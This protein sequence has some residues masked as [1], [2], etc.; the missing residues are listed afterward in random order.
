MTEMESRD[1]RPERPEASDRRDPRT[2]RAES[3]P[4]VLVVDDD[5]PMHR[6][7]ARLLARDGV[8]VLAASD[9]AGAL[10]AAATAHPSLILLDLHLPDMDGLDTLRALR[11]AGETARVVILT[12]QAT[13]PTAREAMRLGAYDFITK[14]FNPDFVRA[15]LR[16]ALA[17]PLS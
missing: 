14:P 3:P 11:A 10:A 12:G 15:V 17:Q 1:E 16:K 2:P 9:G 13:L 5:Q 7:F 8:Q 6:L 4:A